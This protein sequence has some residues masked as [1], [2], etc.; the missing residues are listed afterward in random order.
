MNQID[1]LVLILGDAIA[2]NNL[3]WNVIGNYVWPNYFVGSSYEEEINYLKNWIK[4][5]LSWIDDNLPGVSGN[6][7]SNLAGQVIITEINYQNGAFPDPGDWFEIK[8]VSNSVVDLS[9]YSF[10]DANT[11]NSFRIP[12]GT[13]LAPGEYMVFGI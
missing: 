8:N 11:L 12:A 2:R 6:C 7:E 4:L 10:K 3:R 1:S 9:W 13:I 5:R